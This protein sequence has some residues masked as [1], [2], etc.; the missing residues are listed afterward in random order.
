MDDKA[1]LDENNYG[2]NSKNGK[3]KVYHR[4]VKNRQDYILNKAWIG[5]PGQKKF[6]S[7]EYT[8]MKGG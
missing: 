7:N 3:K 1:P 4:G 6:D 5:L 8:L 2:S